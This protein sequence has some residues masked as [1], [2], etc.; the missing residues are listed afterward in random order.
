MRINKN[1]WLTIAVINLSIVAMLGVLLRSKIMFSIPGIDFKNFL[2]SHSHFA[3]GG[4]ITL[5]LLVL[6]TFEILPENL[7]NK[8]VYKWLLAC[9]LF[10]SYGMLISFPFKGYAF[11]SILLS[12]LFIFVTYGYAWVFIRDVIKCKPA[13]PVKILSIAAMLALVLSS[14]GPFTLAYILASHSVN[15]LLYRDSIYTYLHLQY[16][17]FFTLGVFALFLNHTCNIQNTI[18]Y[19]NATRFAVMLSICVLPTLA[20]SY[21]W[22][23]ENSII[24]AVANVGC[25]C[26]VITIILFFKMMQSLGTVLNKLN[27]FVKKIGL[28]SMIAFALK[29]LIQVGI[30]FPSVATAVFG[31]RPI[32]I[33]YLHLVMLGFVTLYLLAHL[34]QTNYFDNSRDNVKTG[35]IIFASGVIAN[36]LVLMTQGLT[37]MIMLSST[38]YPLLLLVASIW[39]LSGA[40]IIAV[41]S[42][43]IFNEV[44]VS[45]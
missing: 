40:A 41:S 38:M 15:T 13:M 37:A 7:S 24:R 8:P 39:L 16:N 32:I 9:I 20:L 28:L 27:P 44:N 5:C 4:W 26:L 22:H 6:M 12:T 35:I 1:K 2:Q 36:E 10:C 23:F 33:G 31:D 3:F 18:A 17:G 21:L 34:F 42:I 14:A 43:K 25:I 11:V 29:T 45:R 19:K 30:I